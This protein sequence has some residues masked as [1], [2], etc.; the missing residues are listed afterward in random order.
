MQLAKFE[1]QFDTMIRKLVTNK[2][3]IWQEDKEACVEYL[4]DISQ[5]FAG[6]LN[7]DKG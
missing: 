4:T 5:Y 2:N 3:E 7:W 1:N 6:N